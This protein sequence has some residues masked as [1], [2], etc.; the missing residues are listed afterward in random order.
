MKVGDH[1]T[2]VHPFVWLRVLQAKLY[3][4]L[5]A[6]L[7]LEVLSRTLIN[8]SSSTTMERT[9]PSG[10]PK[11]LHNLV[12]RVLCIVWVDVWFTVS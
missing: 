9:S 7:I 10:L 4:N 5:K 2:E 6:T 11:D 3:E 12:F 1:A 8:E